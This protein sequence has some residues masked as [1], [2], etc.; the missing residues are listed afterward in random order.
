[1]ANKLNEAQLEILSL[2]SED[3]E[4]DSLERLKKILM[5]FRANELPTMVG[6]Y[7]E[8]EGLTAEDVLKEHMRT[9]YGRKN[10]HESSH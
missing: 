4:K 8:K 5:E 6:E 3:M 9:P 2:F 1:M 10:K 7:L